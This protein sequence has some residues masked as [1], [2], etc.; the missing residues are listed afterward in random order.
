MTACRVR[1]D[2][3]R[4][5]PCNSL[6]MMRMLDGMAWRT[7]GGLRQRLIGLPS[8]SIYSLAC[9]WLLRGHFHSRSKAAAHGV[10]AD[11]P[12]LNELKQ[13]IAAARLG[14]HAAHSESAKWLAA[15]QRAG[16]AAIDV[17]VAHAELALGAI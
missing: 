12:G 14:S 11:R 7:A 4:K 6:P 16:N 10:L 17:E 5:C 15:N 1:S 8:L 9:C 2:V 3:R 13:I